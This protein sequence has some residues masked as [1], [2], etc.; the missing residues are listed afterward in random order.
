MAGFSL[1]ELLIVMVVLGIIL[2]IAVPNILNALDRGRQSR[3][4]AELRSVASAVEKYSIDNSIYP[5][6]ST[7]AAL[8]TVLEPVYI[9]STPVADA[10]GNSIIVSSTTTNYTIGSGGKD[11]GGLT[12]PGGPTQDF[13]DAIIF[14]DGQF[15]QWPE[16]EQL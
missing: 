12:G 5:T 9:D 1:I 10:W 4:M 15:F 13:D 16:G 8:Q 2:A 3:T 6:A 11:G 14:A 7:A